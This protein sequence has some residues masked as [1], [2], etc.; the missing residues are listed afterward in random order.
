MGQLVLSHLSASRWLAPT[1][2]GARSHTLSASYHTAL[3]QS[4]NQFPDYQY[5]MDLPRSE[6]HI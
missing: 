5:A 6:I 4:Y 2:W 1:P 3:V